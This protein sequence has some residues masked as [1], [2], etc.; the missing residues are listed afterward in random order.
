MRILVTGAAGFVGY[1]VA[2]RLVADGHTVTGLTRSP[3]AT[4]PAG[5]TRHL[6]DIRDPASLPD[7]PFDGVCHLAG[8]AQVREIPHRPAALLAN[9]HRRHAHP[10]RLAAQNRGGPSDLAIPRKC[11]DLRLTDLGVGF[12]RRARFR[13][14]SGAP[15]AAGVK[16]GRRP[17][18]G[19]GLDRGEDGATLVAADGVPVHAAC[20]GGWSGVPWLRS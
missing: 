7:E 15:S 16:A 11:G 3:T 12:V 9:Q 18:A 5:V 20:P 19:L 6:G 10:A 13:R 14:R 2:A 4:L 1:A 17:P 8:L